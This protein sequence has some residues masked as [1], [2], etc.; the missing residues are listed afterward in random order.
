MVFGLD[1]SRASLPVEYL[2][3]VILPFC[4]FGMVFKF[5]QCLENSD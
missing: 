5:H 3:H 2:T 1:F 4:G